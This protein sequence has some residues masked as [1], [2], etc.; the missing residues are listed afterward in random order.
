MLN[1]P[2]QRKA[3]EGPKVNVRT[4]GIDLAKNA[5]MTLLQA[6]LWF[7]PPAA[8]ATSAGGSAAERSTK[9]HLDIIWKR[10]IMQA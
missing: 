7:P 2:S 1:E 9:A 5:G 4:L 8:C 10:G 6:A 3:R